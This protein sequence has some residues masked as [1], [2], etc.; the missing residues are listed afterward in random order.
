MFGL[1]KRFKL[2][3]NEWSIQNK[4]TNFNELPIEI[5][6]CIFDHLKANDIVKFRLVNSFF[7]DLIDSAL[8]LWLK[9]FLIHISLGKRLDLESFFKFIEKTQSNEIVIDCLKEI[10]SQNFKCNVLSENASLKY[11][12]FNTL[13]IL[14]FNYFNIFSDCCVCLQIDSFVNSFGIVK[15]V[16]QSEISNIILNK[17]SKLENLKVSCLLYDKKQ[18][19]TFI[20]NDIY[21]NEFFQ[22]QFSQLFSHVN[23]LQITH[24]TGSSKILIK[25]LRN[26]K[27]LNSL[28]LEE[29]EPINDYLKIRKKEKFSKKRLLVE[30]LR[31]SSVTA[32]MALTVLERLV[33]MNHIKQLSL[34][35]KLS[36]RQTEG[37]EQ[38][39]EDWIQTHLD[40]VLDTHNKKFSDCLK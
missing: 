10:K 19:K 22:N 34:L 4:K 35:T 13:N 36:H 24:Y 5:Y 20:W 17:Y 15:S 8:F 6:F 7:K 28:V 26:F 23:E 21:L 33:N 18:C 11:I 2:E 32:S 37:G 9:R 14:A 25:C 29:C 30:S 31:L 12:H 3:L 38:K 40:Y 16:T 1:R 39:E 27:S